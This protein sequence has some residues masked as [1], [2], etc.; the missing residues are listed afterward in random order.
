QSLTVADE[1]VRR[2]REEQL[3]LPESLGDFVRD[4]AAL[5]GEQPLA[6]WFETDRTLTY[7]GLDRDASALASSLAKRGVR[8]GTHVAVLCGNLPAFPITW[9]ALGRLGA[10]M[11]PVNTAYTNEEVAFILRDSDAQYVVVDTANLEK[12][13]AVVDQ[14]EL[15]D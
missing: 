6:V 10:V 8:K 9:V 2:K 12:V 13:N 5:Y 7:R 15:L 4:Q 1:L 14:L 11:I 3:A